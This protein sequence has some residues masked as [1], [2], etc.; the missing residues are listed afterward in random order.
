M[1]RTYHTLKSYPLR[2]GV[3]YHRPHDSMR[4]RVT[5][6]SPA[7]EVMTDLMRVSAE[8][9]TPDASLE[10]ANNW[11]IKR[12]VRLLLATDEA[13]RIVGLITAS[14]ILGEKP[15]QHIS[16]RGGRRGE[17]LVADI[18]TL[19]NRLEVLRLDEVDHA[20]VGHIVSTLK[21]AGR[22]HALVAETS[23]AGDNQVVCGIFS[24][25]QIARQLGVLIETPE[26]ARTFAE[27]ES[28]LVR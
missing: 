17:L 18:M 20:R 5:L 4:Q 1:I 15:M 3:T 21:Q 10:D 16:A 2:S 13:K 12:G 8:T 7:V 24:V 14:D 23:S 26:I 25:S 6:E 11:M 9:I 22:Q 27:I 28:L 19:Q